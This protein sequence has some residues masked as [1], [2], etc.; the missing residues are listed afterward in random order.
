MIITF[1]PKVGTTVPNTDATYI[2]FLRCVTAACTAA[3]GTTTLTVNPY[4]A[5]NTLDTTKNCILSIDANTEAGGW[6][7]SPGHSVPSSNNNTATAW[8]A[9]TSNGAYSANHRADFH[10]ASGK[11]AY[12]YLKLSFH[13]P[14][15]TTTSSDGYGGPSYP[16]QWGSYPAVQSTFGHSTNTDFPTLTVGAQHYNTDLATAASMTPFKDMAIRQTPNYCSTYNPWYMSMSQNVVK[17]KIAVTANY[18][19]IWEINTA[20]NSYDTGFNTGT[21]NT[22]DYSYYQRYGS[23]IYHGLRETQGWENTYN[24]NP[25]WVS[26]GYLH[27][28]VGRTSS[29]TYSHYPSNSIGAWMRTQTN[30][31]QVSA[32]SLRTVTTTYNTARTNDVTLSGTNAHQLQVPLFKTRIADGPYMGSQTSTLNPPQADPVTGLQVPGA[33]PIIIRS[34]LDGQYNAG[35]ACRGIYKSLS[36][37]FANMKNYWTAANQTFTI[38]GEPYIPVVMYE[39]MWLIRAA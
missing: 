13:I 37:P 22:G 29:T 28:A 31:S 15:A 18:C 35:G 30:T 1:D 7:T 33:Y 36:M 24:D 25:P 34:T 32:P 6:T 39:D 14:P 38:N 2:N 9:V 27:S 23:I 26:W 3:A 20:Y 16:G 21:I 4:T 17:Y 8:T 19:I 11:S 5:S 12:P 10:V